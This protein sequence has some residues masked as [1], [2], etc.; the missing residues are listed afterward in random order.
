MRSDCAKSAVRINKNLSTIGRGCAED[1]ADKAAVVHVLT[2][3]VG[4]DNNNVISRGDTKAGIK[5]HRR[6]GNASRVVR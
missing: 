4:T 1:L 6:V 3:N 5:A 2:R